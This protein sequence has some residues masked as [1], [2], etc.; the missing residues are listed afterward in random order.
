VAHAASAELVE[1]RRIWDQAPHNAFT[2]L[3][4][5]R[6]GWYCTFR[7]GQAH[8][9]PDGAVR[10]IT[11]VDGNTWV[12]A[13]LLTSTQAD[14]RDPKITWVSKNRLMLSAAGA[15]H[16]RTK[17]S[18]QTYAWFSR[19]G[20]HWGR[21]VEIGEPDFW[22]WR[23][24]WQR[25][26]AY[27]IGYDTRGEKF[28]RL[29]SS[30]NGRRFKVLVPRLFDDGYPNEG[31][32]VFQPD[33]TCLAFLRRDGQ[34]NNSAL[35]GI[36]KKPYQEWTW[37]DLGVRAGGPHLLGLPDGRFVAAY[38]S[39][40]GGPKTTLAWLDP[41]ADKLD[42]LLTLPSGG[43]TSYPGLAWHGGLLWVSY[44][45]SHEGKTSIYLAKVWLPPKAR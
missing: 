8:V 34:T 15:F 13:A 2:D 39:Y 43:D 18:H 37:R 35:L 17:A 31:A 19:D 40:E 45:S 10:V 29:Y 14:L 22:L 38:R 3:V 11:S 5:F 20:Y 4:H 33:K 41:A 42:P 28:I 16:D 30:G 21:P 24:T 23:V 44:Y 36:A 26:T 1:C 9:S 7:E 25:G 12:S 32:L 6:G 27:G